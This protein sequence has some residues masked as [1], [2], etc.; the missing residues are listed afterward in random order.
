MYG[1][2]YI[3]A[4]PIGN[5][6]DITLRAIQ[7]L[8]D[9]DLI[10]A[11]DTRVSSYLLN[12]YEIKTKK[13]SLHKFNE[14]EKIAYIFSLLEQGQS[15]ALISDAGTPLVSD[16]G[17]YLVNFLI[18]KNI[19]IIPIPGACAVITALSAC[20]LST[21]KFSFYG[22]LDKNTS[23]RK[24]FLQE[25][26]D[27]EETL[28]F[29]ESAKRI[30]STIE[31]CIQV[32]EENTK[33]TL[34]KEITKI[35]EKFIR[36]NLLEIKTFLDANPDKIKGEF[37]LLLENKKQKKEQS[38]SKKD[39]ELIT[40]LKEFVPKNKLSKILANYLDLNKNKLYKIL[41]EQNQS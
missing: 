10:L 1:S 35:N 32:F 40:N 33:C 19:N 22:F 18:Q 29:Y 26:I 7:T 4:T 21:A 24:T 5:T 27:Q 12:L 8:K 30:K 9:V 14:Q 41:L 34:A 23:K 2:F 28:I 17:S 38:L 37:V 39:L 36:G 13:T 15:L 20:G 16:P 6:K 3:V 11:E 31:I 25:K